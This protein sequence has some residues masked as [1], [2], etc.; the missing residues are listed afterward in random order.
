MNSVLVSTLS[1][2]ALLTISGL[3]A[4]EAVDDPKPSQVELLARAIGK[5]EATCTP[6]AGS[7]RKDVEKIFGAGQPI[8]RDDVRM[9]VEELKRAP[10]AE[11]RFWKYDLCENGELHVRY[12]GATNSVVESAHYVNPYQ[13]NGPARIPTDSEILAGQV[14]RLEQITVILDAFVKRVRVEKSK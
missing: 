9:T 10:T 11:S 2:T 8:H 1:F 5:L 3:G 13:E 4:A 14:K 6:A 12:D 7:S